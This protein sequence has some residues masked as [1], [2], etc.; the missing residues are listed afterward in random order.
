MQV[1]LV[2]LSV[3]L[4]S[5][6]AGSPALSSPGRF[7]QLSQLFA[8][9]LIFVVLGAVLGPSV[10][11]WISAPA[12]EALQPL[13]ALALGT[14]GLLM[15]LNLEPRLLRALPGP[16]ARAVAV[17][18]GAAFLAV[19]GPLAVPFYLLTELTLLRAVGAAGVLGAV[20]SVSS[21]HFAVIW[22]RAG[23]LNRATSFSLAL[24]A[25][26]DDLVALLAL[27]LALVFGTAANPL[28]GLSLVG[29]AVLLGLLCGA[30]LLFLLAGGAGDAERIAILLGGVLLVSG[31][32]AY[33]RVS[34]LLAGFACG[35]TLSLVGGAHTQLAY[36]SLARV[37]RPMFL[38]LGFLV[39]AHLTVTQARV[40]I[41]LPAFVALRAVGKVLGGRGAAA[42]ARG[43]LSLPPEPG[44][45]LLAQG[46]VSLC[47]AVE[48]LT[49]T[50]GAGAELVFGIAVLGALVNEVLGGGAFGR[51][52][53]PKAPPAE[54]PG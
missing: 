39:G 9:G 53:T 27:A 45:A 36:R 4:L 28:I 42:V 13:V 12:L 7:F 29:A 17:Q 54:V 50:R 6:L 31:A 35:A 44:F 3:V 2:V 21:A 51:A 49:L 43:A 25:I 15:G 16:V 48:Y 40:W 20:A 23:R 30:L 24:L 33:L 14:G 41:L 10:L 18:A 5:I 1:M 34:T 32:A 26:L 52:L 8:S 46:G 11:G 37:E 47:V 38:V 22:Y 19:A